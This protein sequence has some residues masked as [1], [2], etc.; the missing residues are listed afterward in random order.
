MAIRH[1]YDLRSSDSRIE[2]SKDMLE[3]YRANHLPNFSLGANYLYSTASYSESIEGGYLPT[4]VVDDTGSLVPNLSG[5]VDASGTPIFNQY[6]YMPDINFDVEAGSI[7]NVSAIMTQ[8]IYMGGKVTTAVKMARLG[9]GVAQQERRRTEAAVIVETDEAFY[10]LIKL[11]EMVLT[12][13]RY[14]EAVVAFLRDVSNAER[15]GMA[16][17]ND[18]LKV[19]VKLSEARL[20]CQKAEN[21]LRLAKMNLCYAIGLPLTTSDVSVSDQFDLN[22]VIEDQELDVTSRPEYSML[23]SQVSMKELE[24]ELAKSDF[25]PS[26][27]AI[28]SYGYFNGATINGSPLLNSASFTGGVMVSV[29]LFHWGEGRRT[30]SA[31]R[32]EVEIAQ[33]QLDD[34][35]QKMRLELLREI[36]LYEDATAQVRMTEMMV[37][38][39]EENMR[40]SRNQY[41]AGMETLADSMEAQAMWQKSMSDLVEAKAAQRM[42]YSK[43]LKAAGL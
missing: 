14:E 21:G 33:N 11:E 40:I 34:L 27:S 29:P 2:A 6:A 23:E 28:A 5:A 26:V 30:A 9:V 10:T 43:Y 19:E 42:A 18:V 7:F 39:A 41:S 3:A 16:H 13:Q 35:T 32:R 31:R 36:N 38:Q 20:M 12:A 22:F 24:V 8:P 25:K 4:Y 1:N 15:H 37:I 17:R